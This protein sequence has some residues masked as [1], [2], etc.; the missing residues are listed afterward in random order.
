MAHS[1]DSKDQKVEEAKKGKLNRG[2][3]ER[4]E[5]K[6]VYYEEKLNR[7]KEIGDM[8]ETCEAYNGL[9]TVYTALAE[10]DTTTRKQRPKHIDR[11]RSLNYGRTERYDDRLKFHKEKLKR[12]NE[13]PGDGLE[14]YTAY[15]GLAKTYRAMAIQEEKGINY[16]DKQ[17]SFFPEKGNGNTNW[18]H[19]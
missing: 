10:E 18:M 5:D 12:A 8:R 1:Q 14:K 16:D 11:D 4:Y 19:A 2:R 17:N 3:T 13:A 6:I 9:A 15:E 7:A